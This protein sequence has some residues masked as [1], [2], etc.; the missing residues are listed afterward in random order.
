MTILQSQKH[1]TDQLKLAAQP[2]FSIS[3]SALS[4]TPVE[5]FKFRSAFKL[6]ICN[7]RRC[8][9]LNKLVVDKHL[10]LPCTV[11]NKHVVCKQQQDIA[12]AKEKIMQQE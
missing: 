4:A 3:F 8:T 10:S 12:V 5:Y 11:L 9:E 6:Y 7:K 1:C 2:F